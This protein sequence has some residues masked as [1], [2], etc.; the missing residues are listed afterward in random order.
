M[1][2]VTDLGTTYDEALESLERISEAASSVSQ[3]I[4]NLQTELETAQQVCE[5][6]GENIQTVVGAAGEAFEGTFGVTISNIEEAT[7]SVLEDLTDEAETANNQ[8]ENYKEAVADAENTFQEE[9]NTIQSNIETVMEA[10]REEFLKYQKTVDS[11]EAGSLALSNSMLQTHTLFIQE[12]TSL[13]NQVYSLR[14]VTEQLFNDLVSEIVNE[15]VGLITGNFNEFR[16]QLTETVKTE[17]INTFQTYE[18]NFRNLHNQFRELAETQIDNCISQGQEIFSTV[19]SHLENSLQEQLQPAFEKLL[20]EI[21]EAILQEIMENVALSSFGVEV[22][23]TLAPILPELVV[24][25]LMLEVINDFL[26]SFN[27][28]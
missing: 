10:V 23:A 18:G 11:V 7:T 1:A 22:T 21:L 6:A 24:A 4:E 16:E 19:R 17:V 15:H 14:D 8:L 12:F 13:E 5:D 9:I 20:D 2:D 25:K 28:F 3:E 26:S 27:P